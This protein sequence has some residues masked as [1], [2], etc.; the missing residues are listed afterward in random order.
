MIAA[1]DRPGKEET[2]R[3]GDEIYENSIQPNVKSEDQGRYAVIDV[4]TGDYEIDADEL[5]A[6]DRLLARQPNAQVWLRQ[7]GSRYARRFGRH[8]RPS[9]E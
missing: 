3:L 5:A 9:A 8:S 7:I 4:I 2:A 1:T 6:S